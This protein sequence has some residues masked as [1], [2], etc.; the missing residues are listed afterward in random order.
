MDVHISR[1]FKCYYGC[2]DS[3]HK[4]ELK[5]HTIPNLRTLLQ[6]SRL[7]VNYSGV[8][9]VELAIVSKHH[10]LTSI[11]QFFHLD[12]ALSYQNISL[13]NIVF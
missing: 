1:N 3:K 8:S 12:I 5:K 13:Q 4:T 2:A 6:R 9:L 7:I 11:N 10:N